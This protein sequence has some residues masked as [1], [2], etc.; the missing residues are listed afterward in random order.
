[1]ETTS[2]GQKL[3]GASTE[4]LGVITESTFALVCGIILGFYFEW[5]LTLVALGC[6]P[7][8]M[9]GGAMNSKL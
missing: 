5:R 4:G 1:M 3:N 2:S 8:M 6:V 7:F 9:F